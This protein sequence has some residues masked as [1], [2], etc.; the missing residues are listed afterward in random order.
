L[1]VSERRHPR[2]P[3]RLRHAA[4]GGALGLAL[5]AT[6]TAEVTAPVVKIAVFEFELEDLSPASALLGEATSSAASMSKVSEVARQELE[7]SGRYRIVDVKPADAPPL[8]ARAL[9]NCDGCEAEIARQLG[10]D[11]SLIG[12]VRRVTQTDYYVVVQ[13]RDARDGKL[14]NAQEANF[15]G[16]EE[17]WP[18]GVRMLIRHQVL[19]SPE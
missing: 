7:R 15:A 19:A 13:I 14:L 11:E 10:A 17:G 5:A 18:S 2:K 16:G 9:R 3:S 1:R 8:K 12:V 4:W 6:V